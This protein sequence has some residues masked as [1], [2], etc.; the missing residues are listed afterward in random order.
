M[1][2]TV[3]VTLSTLIVSGVYVGI[4]IIGISYGRHLKYCMQAHGQD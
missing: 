2:F 3:L 1:I 4:I